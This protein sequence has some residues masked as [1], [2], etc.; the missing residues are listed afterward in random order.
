[1]NF[2][3]EE[4]GNIPLNEGAEMTKRFRSAALPGSVLGNYFGREIL[5]DILRQPTCVG[6]RFYYG[7]SEKLEN[8]LVLV[9]VDAQQNDLV[10]GIIA[11]KSVKCPPTC[12]VKNILNSNV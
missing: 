1:M 5:E 11:D 9:G 4:G 2:T 7:T 8:Q 12:G 3:G 10:D 6:I